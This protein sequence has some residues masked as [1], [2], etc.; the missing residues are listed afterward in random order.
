MIDQEA[1]QTAYASDGIYALQLEVG[2]RCYQDCVYCYMN[3]LPQEQ[4]TLSDELIVSILQEARDLGIS[5]VEW[6]GGEPLL[7]NSIA[8][9]LAVARDLGLRNNIWTG[10]LP[11]ADPQV[12]RQVAELARPGL[13]AVHVSTVDPQL[14]QTL[15]PHRGADDLTAILTAVRSLLDLGYPAAQMLNSVTLTG[16]QSAVDAL[17]TIDH[18]A[19]EFGIK[20]C[21]NVY[22]TYQRPGTPA[23]EL[24]R[25]IPDPDLVATVYAHLA[26]QW[27]VD[28]L[29]M[30]CV[31]KQY[32]SATVAVLCDG[33]VTPCATIREP[34]APS[35][36]DLPSLRT[37]FAQHREHLIFKRFK[38]PLEQPASCR[39]CELST[40][41]WGCR[42]RAYAANLGMYGKDPRCFRHA[43]S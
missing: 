11:L 34:D 31:S 40:H 2:D 20:T 13:V 41:C 18:F 27:Q 39:S 30:N 14:Y 35:L 33:K 42:S 22:H 19:T 24:A 21:V 10:G 26:D 17:A 4:N 38:D 16:L 9:L 8:D 23:G 43:A 36:H 5:A 3:A 6:L 15:H 28:E 25:F 37:I 12:R 1:L 32:C 29:P 7:R